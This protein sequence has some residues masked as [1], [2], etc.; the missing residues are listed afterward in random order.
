MLLIINAFIENNIIKKKKKNWIGEDSLIIQ[1]TQVHVIMHLDRKS[2]SF[3][4][5]KIE[6]LWLEN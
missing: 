3:F 5:A 4:F 6:F 1:N 2:F